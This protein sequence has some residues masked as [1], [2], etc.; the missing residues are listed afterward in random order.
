MMELMKALNRTVLELLKSEGLYF[1]PANIYICLVARK[2]MV[3]L[4]A[5][6]KQYH[7]D[8]QEVSGEE[9]VAAHE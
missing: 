4:K 9:P 6:F 3:E 5:N 2:E 1:K 7:F 8:H